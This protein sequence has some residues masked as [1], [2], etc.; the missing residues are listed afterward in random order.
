MCGDKWTRQSAGNLQGERSPTNLQ[1]PPVTFPTIYLN[2]PKYF[3]KVP[4]GKSL[5]NWK[6]P[7]NQRL[8]ELLIR[9]PPPRTL[10]GEGHQSV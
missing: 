9:K 8:D 2:L 5:I 3:H 4:H 1:P 7:G 10:L 6:V